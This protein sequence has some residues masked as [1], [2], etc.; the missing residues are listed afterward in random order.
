[1]ADPA[2]TE[3]STNVAFM[4]AQRRRRW[5]NIKT[6]SVERLV[7]AGESL[8]VKIFAIFMPNILFYIFNFH[9]SMQLFSYILFCISFAS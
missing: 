4:L 7:F 5:T 8:F 1:M 2:N 6:T 9:L 3:Y